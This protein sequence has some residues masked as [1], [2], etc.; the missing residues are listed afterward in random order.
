M[1][2]SAAEQYLLELMN[3]ARLDPAGEAARFG[4]SLNKDLAPG[5]LTATAKQVLAPNALLESAATAHSLWMLEHDVFSHTGVNG[6]DG[7][8]RIA[9]QGYASTSWGENLAFTGSTAAITMEGSIAGLNRDLFLS[10]T[11]RTNLMNSVYREVGL[12]AET[13]IFTQAGRNY[14]AAMLTENFGT[15][16]TARFVTGVAYADRNND[17][18]YSMGE[19]KAGVTF[20]V[21]T[22]SAATADAGGYSVATGT[23]AATLVSG[24]SGALAF[25]ANVDMSH[26]NVKL[27][28]V[29]DLKFMSSGNITLI[30]GVRNVDL[31]GIADLNATGNPAGNHLN[32][33]AGNN[34]LLGRG[35]NDVLSGFAGKDQINGGLGDDN[36]TGGT[37]NDV[38]TGD[39]GSDTFVFSTGFGL[40]QISDFKLSQSDHLSLDHTLWTGIKTAAAVVA[41]FAHVGTGEVVF[42]FGAGNEIHLKGLTTLTGLDATLLLV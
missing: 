18:F 26:G 11:H 1:S 23:N 14:N 19:G 9:A 39:L 15:R 20:T 31:L 7:G 32:G 28:L 13:G 37:G 6:T 29:G 30:S 34:V 33:N 3:R 41:Q 2:I 22:A 8:Q 42:D 21:G 12:G 10:A 25:Q 35:G 17:N 36:I 27:D 4:I 24:T 38:L 16:G 40:D 5:T